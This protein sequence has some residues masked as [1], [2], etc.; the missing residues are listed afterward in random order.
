MLISKKRFFDIL[1]RLLSLIIFSIFILLIYIAS[2]IIH[3]FPVFYKHE[4]LGEKGKPFIMIKF[5]SML[6]GESKGANDDEK[7]ITKWGRMLRKTSIDELPVLINV[8]KGDM[9]FVGPRPMPLKYLKRFNNYQL[10]RL[11]IK[12]GIT[13]LAQINGRNKLSWDEKFK[14][15]VEY[16]NKN[17]LPIDILIILKTIFIVFKGE[18]VKSVNSE[19]MPEFFGSNQDEN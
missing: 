10:K 9:S 18:G 11:N 19:I 5:R 13:G 2:M 8:L 17:S 7:R 1:L 16:V 15:D 4:R 14:L 6:V 12:P 3:G